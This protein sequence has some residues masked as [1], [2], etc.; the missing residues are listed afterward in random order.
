MTIYNAEAGV[1]IASVQASDDGLSTVAFVTPSNIDNVSLLS[2]LGKILPQYMVPSAIY[3]LDRLPKTTNDKVDHKTIA[4]NQAYLIREAQPDR[5][6]RYPQRKQTQPIAVERPKEAPEIQR[7][8]GHNTAAMRVSKIW[9][10]I[11]A[12]GGLPDLD[13]NFF[14]LGGHRYVTQH[15][16]MRLLIQ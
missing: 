8:Q 10:G 16:D 1:T 13:V 12:L 5:L 15:A 2:Q 7:S 4:A 3:R 6:N 9:K 14:D 11:L